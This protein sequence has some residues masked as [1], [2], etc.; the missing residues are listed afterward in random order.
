MDAIADTVILGEYN[1]PTASHVQKPFFITRILREM[2][3]VHLDL[4]SGLSEGSGHDVLA[5]TTIEEK[6][7]RV[8]YAALG[9][10]SHRM[11]SSMSC[12]ERA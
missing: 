9:L 7:V 4:C 6:D 2:I 11:A 5:K 10:S 3:I 8:Y 12:G 1:P